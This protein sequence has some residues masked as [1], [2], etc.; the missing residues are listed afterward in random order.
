M[1]HAE[2]H[3]IQFWEKRRS[4]PA[5]HYIWHITYVLIIGLVI[6]FLFRDQG[7]SWPV[8]KML[9][10]IGASIP[11]GMVWGWFSYHDYE[12]QYQKALKKVNKSQTS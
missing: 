10:A 1:H 11:A 4:K 3:L 8:W 6:P 7:E 12:K 5:I 2:K 9:L